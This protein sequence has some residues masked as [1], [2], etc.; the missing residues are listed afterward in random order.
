MKNVQTVLKY[1][2]S[3]LNLK[4]DKYTK[5]FFYNN[6][7]DRFLLNHKRFLETRRY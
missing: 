6:K 3:Y 4:F 5:D 2:F 7:H 1:A